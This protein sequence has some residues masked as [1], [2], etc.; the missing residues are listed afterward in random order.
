MSLAGQWDTVNDEVLANSHKKLT[1]KSNENR[2]FG[3]HILQDTIWKL[4]RTCT[5]VLLAAAN[6]CCSLARFCC[7]ARSQSF[8]ERSSP[9]S[10]CHCATVSGCGSALTTQHVRTVVTLSRK[11][12]TQS[13]GIYEN[14][15][16]NNTTNNK[17]NKQICVT[18]SV[19]HVCSS[20]G[21]DNGSH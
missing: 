5:A 16:S 21:R 1:A 7:I 13:T 20:R 4:H 10:C 14:N 11:K 8:S 15:N 12:C 9:N 2:M 3:M 17:E 19:M 18:E 6:D